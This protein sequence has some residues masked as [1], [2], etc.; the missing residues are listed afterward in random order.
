LST[1]V[2]EKTIK[3]AL[4]GCGR[5]SNRH[6]EAIGANENVEIALVCDIDEG[7]AKAAGER[8]SVPY[9]TDYRKIEGVDLISVL[10]PSGLHPRHA[11]EI[12]ETTDV[13]IGRAHV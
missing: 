1:A 9:L 13:Q 8:L 3:V 5:I 10:T 7:R 4:V 6:I 11:A 12:A 2:D